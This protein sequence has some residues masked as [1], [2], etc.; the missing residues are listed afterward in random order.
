MGNRWKG[1]LNDEEA[2]DALLEGRHAFWDN[3]AV[4]H[5]ML[6]AALQGLAE[7]DSEERD[8]HRQYGDPYPMEP[9][10]D[11][12]LGG[13][14]ERAES[15]AEWPFTRSVAKANKAYRERV[16]AKFGDPNVSAKW[17]RAASLLMETIELEEREEFLMSTSSRRIARDWRNVKAAVRNVRRMRKIRDQQ[18][19]WVDQLIAVAEDPAVPAALRQEAE[20]FYAQQMELDAAVEEVAT[21]TLAALADWA[22]RVPLFTLRRELGE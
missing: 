19:H 16:R 14:G 18:Q 3:P 6:A 11:K 2:M 1:F 5:E 13:F 12:M 10:S 20:E 17:K 21:N 8:R 4:D 22:N 15:P 9:G 7:L